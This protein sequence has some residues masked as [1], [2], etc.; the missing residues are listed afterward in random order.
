MAYG[1]MGSSQKIN[2][3]FFPSLFLEAWKISKNG[4]G[5]FSLGSDEDISRHLK[6]SASN[7]SA[8]KKSESYYPYTYLFD[9]VVVLGRSLRLARD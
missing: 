8:K 3:M 4:G 6:I 5:V 9:A 1:L 7:K 2:V